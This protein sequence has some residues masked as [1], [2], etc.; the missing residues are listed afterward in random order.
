MSKVT[1]DR[2]PQI[3]NGLLR[4]QIP[5]E[6]LGFVPE[7]K[8][9][10]IEKGFIQTDS[11]DFQAG[12]FEL[13]KVHRLIRPE[14]Q[15][16]DEGYGLSGVTK[17]FY[18]T[19]PRFQEA[20][21]EL[22]RFVAKKIIPFDFIFQGTPNIRFH[23]PV[24]QRSEFYTDSGIYMN[25]HTDTL[26]GHSFEEI[27]CWFPLTLCHGNN[28]LFLASLQ[29]S[30]IV[31]RQFCESIDY[32]WDIYHGSGQQ[33]FLQFLRASPKASDFIL[34]KTLPL[35]MKPGE[36]VFFDTRCIHSP[37]DSSGEDHTRVSVDFRLIPVHAYEKIDREYKSQGRSGRKFM[38]GD[39]FYA[40]SALQI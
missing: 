15:V 8:R 16:A 31:L 39:V 20:Y 21:L 24:K 6:K 12:N 2:V 38:R 29:D 11:P 4:T 40:Q 37:G 28:S 34:E 25:H 5:V 32:S 30:M 33:R 7:I 18:E 10:L 14:A 35:S 27:N 13:E 1:I 3:D 26:L 17:S 22:I 23:F 9:L 19:S 36:A